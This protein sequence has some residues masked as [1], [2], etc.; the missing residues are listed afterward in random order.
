M[1]KI[2]ERI[3]SVEVKENGGIMSRVVSIKFLLEFRRP[4][5]REIEV[6]RCWPRVKESLPSIDRGFVF[7]RFARHGS[8]IG[9]RGSSDESKKQGVLS[10]PIFAQGGAVKNFR[11]LLNFPYSHKI[12]E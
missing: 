8:Y 6:G 9:I 7:T 1:C 2:R 12:A 10:H 3:I 11:S 4:G 5:D